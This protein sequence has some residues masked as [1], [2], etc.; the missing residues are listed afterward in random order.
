M[1][2]KKDTFYKRQ[3]FDNWGKL[4]YESMDLY[5]GIY[6]L[7]SNIDLLRQR[8]HNLINVKNYQYET[9]DAFDVSLF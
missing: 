1:K 4:L 9:D 6:D 8:G 2:N 3:L 5:N 7:N